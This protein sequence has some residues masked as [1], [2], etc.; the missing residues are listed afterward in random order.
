M[1][2][3]GQPT[4]TTKSCLDRQPAPP[5][6]AAKSRRMTVSD[7][8]RGTPPNGQP[9]AGGPRA[10]EQEYATVRTAAGA[11]Q[12]AQPRVASPSGPPLQPRL[13]PNQPPP[14][15]PLPAPGLP[16]GARPGTAQS[17]ATPAVGA[18][19]PPP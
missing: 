2:M 14:T 12:A 15:K 9:P 6:R 16:D 7:A 11:Q 13:A 8:S 19:P 5:P 1:T 18:M 10:R 4:T 3:P 17:S